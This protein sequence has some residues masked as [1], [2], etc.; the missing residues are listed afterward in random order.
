LPDFDGA[1][2]WNEVIGEFFGPDRVN[3]ENHDSFVLLKKIKTG[4]AFK[5]PAAPEMEGTSLKSEIFTT[6]S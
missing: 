6:L 3:D 1:A 5:S 4:C 2:D